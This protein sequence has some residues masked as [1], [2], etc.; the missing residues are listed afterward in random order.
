MLLKIMP[1]LWT[2][3]VIIAPQPLCDPLT[4]YGLNGECCQMCPPGTSMSDLGTCTTPQCLQCDEDEYQDTYTTDT[5]CKRQPYCDPNKNF[6][7]SVQTSRTQKNTCTCKLGSHCSSEACFT[8]VPH[9]RCEPGL[10]V[11]FKGNHTHDTVCQ[12]CPDGTFSSQTS[13]DSECLT[14]TKCES[15]Y[16]IMQNGSSQSD[17]VCEKN[18]RTHIVIACLLVP[19]IVI[20]LLAVMK[21]WH[22]KRREKDFK[23]KGCNEACVQH[24]KEVFPILNV[25]HETP[26]SPGVQVLLADSSSTG[27]PEENEDGPNLLVLRDLLLSD[28]GNFVTQENGK[29][30]VLS[31]QESQSRTETS[32][33]SS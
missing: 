20:L 8:C 28:K 26:M 2:A 7:I 27:E 25:I 32:E 29:A 4:Q 24:D 22:T 11:L 5:K 31:R 21:I 3:V 33:L 15:G 10:G 9:R 13:W 16:V 1:I 12:K 30:E 18:Q 17:V 19:L 14:W 6:Q 23:G